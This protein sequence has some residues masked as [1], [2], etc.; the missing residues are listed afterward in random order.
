MHSIQLKSHHIGSDGRLQVDLPNLHDTDV[1]V[2][3]VYQPAQNAKK[4]EWSS[5]FLSAFG[6]WQGEAL[7]RAPQEEQMERESFQGS[8][9]GI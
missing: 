4:R 1:D 2:I 9:K 5:A 7:V 8:Q 3:I 6:S